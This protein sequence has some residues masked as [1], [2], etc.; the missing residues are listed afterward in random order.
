MRDHSFVVEKPRSKDLVLKSFSVKICYNVQAL[1]AIEAVTP[2]RER[3]N[4]D[5][6]QP[7]K[8]YMQ[9]LEQ[10][11]S[12]GG[13]SPLSARS[14]WYLICDKS[15]N[16][17]PECLVMNEMLARYMIHHKDLELEKFVEVESF[18]TSMTE[19]DSTG[20]YVIVYLYE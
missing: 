9:K 13:S 6:P 15:R 17:E 18:D 7:W 16:N 19:T 4:L 11:L 3:S 8:D 10:S 1:R 12:R 14:P 5:K 20:D 2:K